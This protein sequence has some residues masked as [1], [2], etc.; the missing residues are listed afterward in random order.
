[1][2]FQGPNPSIWVGGLDPSV[3]EQ[4]LYDFFYRI[5]P[6]ASVRVCM[7]SVTQKSLGYGY[8]NFQDPA[9]AEKALDQAG[10]KL[11]GRFL[12]IAKIQRDPAKRRSG[13]TNIV[14]KKLPTS[15]DTN[16]LKEL[17]GKFGR[18]TAIGLACDEK[19]ESRGYARISYERE[20]SAAEAVKEMDGLELDGQ[21]ITVERFQAQYRDE[22]L[23]Q[24]TNLYVKNLDASVTDEKLKEFFSKIGEVT[25][26]KVRDL[27]AN[28]KTEGG[29]GYVAFAKHEDASRAVEELNDKPADIAKEGGNLEVL[30]FRAREERQRDRERE[31][32]E[33]AQQYSKYPNLYVKGFDDTVTSENLKE[34]FERYGETVSVTVMMDKETGVSRC[35][36]F[37]SMKDQNAASKAI[38]E[39]NGSTFLCPR[40]LFVTYAVRK[41][42]RRQNLEERNKQRMRQNPAMGPMGGM[43]PMGFMN[44]PPGFGMGGMPFG[45][46]QRV[47]MMPM[48]P[49]RGG[50]GPNPMNQMRAGPAPSR[51]SRDRC[52]WPRSRRPLR[53]RTLP[54]SSTPSAPTSRRTSSA[55]AS[56]D[57]LS[58]ASLPWRRRLPVCCSRWT[59]VKSFPCSTTPASSTLRLAR[60][61]MCSTATPWAC[62]HV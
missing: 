53:A 34:L 36:G 6:V 33:R 5:G 28:A 43:N 42:A 24:F 39:L 1:M 38:Q 59:T 60:P 35:F 20:E 55:S 25:S 37:V 49:M 44:G 40:P 26:C 61:R 4:A 58:A 14:V 22:Q 13:V 45:M 52:R 3:K 19:G 17:F 27:G 54:P 56:T 8:V 46:N 57:T 31:R 9:D 41:D 7:D 18:L 47:P 23:K 15:V 12:R 10:T 16:A 50:M 62:K 29:L 32:R 48:N 21:S 11:N 2:S 51:S 30:R